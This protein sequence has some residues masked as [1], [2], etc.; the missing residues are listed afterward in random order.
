MAKTIKPARVV[1]S[2][3]ASVEFASK[4]RRIADHRNMTM[5]EVL[6]KFAGAAIDREN[7][8]CVEEIHAEYG[9]ES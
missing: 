6:E 2:I 3:A 5:V 9:G 4:I 8:K 1:T 7:R